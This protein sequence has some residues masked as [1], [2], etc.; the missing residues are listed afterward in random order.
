V[1]A[2]CMRMGSSPEE[3]QQIR[4]FGVIARK[5]H[6]SPWLKA[7]A[8]HHVHLQLS[9]AALNVKALSYAHKE[10]IAATSNDVPVWMQGD[11]SMHD[12]TVWRRRMA[13][14]KHPKA[15]SKLDIQ[16]LLPH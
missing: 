16:R 9:R 12:V 4:A 10:F 13:L 6:E 11:Q 14:R 8:A 5:F 7:R 15:R 1:G 2:S 3:N